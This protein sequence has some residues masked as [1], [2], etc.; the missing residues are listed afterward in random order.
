[1]E[2][3]DDLVFFIGKISTFEIRTK[4]IN[5]S[6]PATLTTSQQSCGFGKGTPT[7]FA[8]ITDVIDETLVFFFGPCSFVC[9]GFLATRR[10]SHGDDDDDVCVCVWAREK[11]GRGR[12]ESRMWGEL[13]YKR[14]WLWPSW[15]IHV[16]E[17]ERE[18]VCFAVLCVGDLVGNL[19]LFFFFLLFLLGFCFLFFFFLSFLIISWEL[20]QIQ[21]Q[22]IVSFI[23]VYLKSNIFLD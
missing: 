15:Y 21:K 3:D 13:S 20:R 7:T 17:R 14:R 2:F 6:E 4:V 11:K 8:V 18:A 22:H 10:P 16:R 5:P 9:V 12:Q 23:W 19:L 1:M